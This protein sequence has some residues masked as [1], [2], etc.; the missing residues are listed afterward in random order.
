ME[1]KSNNDL[2][3]INQLGFLMWYTI[4]EEM[5]VFCYKLSRKQYDTFIAGDKHIS[6][7]SS[8]HFPAALGQLASIEEDCCNWGMTSN[9]KLAGS[10]TDTIKW[11][12]WPEWVARN[13]GWYRALLQLFRDTD[14]SVQLDGLT[15]D[16]QAFLRLHWTTGRDTNSTNNYSER[17][18]EHW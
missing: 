6:Q 3:N 14:M 15:S 17:H 4:T 13:A 18:L 1:K 16:S 8:W 12:A 10:W 7:I 5:T 11:Y 2:M 9:F